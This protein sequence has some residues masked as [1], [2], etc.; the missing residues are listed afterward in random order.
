[1]YTASGCCQAAHCAKRKHAAAF[2]RGK[3]GGEGAPVAEDEDGPPQKKQ[4]SGQGSGLQAA[5]REEGGGVGLRLEAPTKVKAEEGDGTGGDGEPPC[6]GQHLSGE[7]DVRVKEEALHTDGAPAC[8]PAAQHS[9]EGR[10]EQKV[11]TSGRARKG[12][13]GSSLCQHDGAPCMAPCG[14]VA[15]ASQGQQQQAKKHEDGEGD[16]GECSGFWKLAGLDIALDVF[17][18][19]G[20]GSIPACI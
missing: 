14:L 3:P 1:M 9:R 20:W 5:Y 16:T 6:K 7:V 12:L 13:R 19:V 10:E 2:P 4:N 8:A 11:F 18:Q 15:T 17:M